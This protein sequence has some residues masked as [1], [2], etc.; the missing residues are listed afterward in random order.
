MCPEGAHHE[1][2]WQECKIKLSTA[3]AAHAERFWTQ[4][5]DSVGDSWNPHISQQGLLGTQASLVILTLSH[6]GIQ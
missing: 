1:Q 5:S 6:V 2:F 3:D 4:Q